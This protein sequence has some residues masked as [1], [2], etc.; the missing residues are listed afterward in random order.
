MIIFDFDQTLVD[1]SPVEALRAARRWKD[2]MAQRR[3]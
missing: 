2:V 3:G 1:T